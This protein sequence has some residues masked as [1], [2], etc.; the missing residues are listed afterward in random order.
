MELS[1]LDGKD[2]PNFTEHEQINI[3]K[4]LKLLEK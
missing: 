4:R 2:V 3:Q 1:K